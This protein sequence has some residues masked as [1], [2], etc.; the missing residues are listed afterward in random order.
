MGDE[1]D[2]TKRYAVEARMN[3][4]LGWTGLGR[5]AGSS[6]GSGTMEVCC[7]VIDFNIANRVIAA[8]LPE[9]NL[10]TTRA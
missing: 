7:L 2:L 1:Q 3:E 10:A 8:I 4:A 5:C 9:L 6:I